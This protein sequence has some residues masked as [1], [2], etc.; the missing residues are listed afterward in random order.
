MKST[1]LVFGAFL[2]VSTVAAAKEK[3]KPANSSWADCT[4]QSTEEGWG[5]VEI[6]AGKGSDRI[7]VEG[8]KAEFLDGGECEGDLRCAIA[9]DEPIEF[10]AGD[11]DV[12]F[13]LRKGRPVL[14]SGGTRAIIE[15][16]PTIDGVGAKAIKLFGSCSTFNL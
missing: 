5:K 9:N 12:T 11:K 4:A 10:K 13:Q 2:V 1:L 6:V 3:R 7:L 14:K 8:Q 15:I 16:N